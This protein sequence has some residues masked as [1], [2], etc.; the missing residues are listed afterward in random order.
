V[1]KENFQNFL[2]SFTLICTFFFSSSV[3]KI[4]RKVRNVAALPSKELSNAKKLP[5][6]GGK[7]S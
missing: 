7:K 4:K 5:E 6:K 3:Q 1:R 2:G